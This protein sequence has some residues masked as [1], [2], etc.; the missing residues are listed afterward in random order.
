MNGKNVLG[1]VCKTKQPSSYLTAS[2]WLFVPINIASK[3]DV[4]PLK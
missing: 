4:L 2:S 1:S 3:T